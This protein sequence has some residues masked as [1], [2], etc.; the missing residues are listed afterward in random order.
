MADE[1]VKFLTRIDPDTDRK[2]KTAPHHDWRGAGYVDGHIMK[3]SKPL[4]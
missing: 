2:M 1:K 4:C 3:K